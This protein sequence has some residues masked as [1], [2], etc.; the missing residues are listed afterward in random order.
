MRFYK[1][2]YK[3]AEIKDSAVCT[4]DFS[5]DEVEE[6]TSLLVLPAT[7][8]KHIANDKLPVSPGSG[9]KRFWIA[10]GAI[11]AIIVSHFVFQFSFIQSENVRLAE[12]LVKNEKLEQNKNF[13]E[14][15]AGG[16]SEP[17][18]E[19]KTVNVTEDASE[20]EIK[21]EYAAKKTQEAKKVQITKKPQIVSPPAEVKSNRTTPTR[22]VNRKRE[23]SETRA[24]RLRRVEKA[25]TGV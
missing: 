23:E 3:A 19:R 12:N 22:V 10:G 6:T 17:Q 18:T 21:T 8:E 16:A 1:N 11:L 24:E 7:R 5:P 13:V 2:E 4:V 14:P 25:L 15:I 20:T 9:Q